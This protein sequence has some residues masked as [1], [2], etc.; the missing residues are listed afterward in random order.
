MFAGWI[1]RESGFEAKDRAIYKHES[2]SIILRESIES[3]KEKGNIREIGK[4]VRFVFYSLPPY[5]QKG[6]LPSLCARYGGL[7][8]YLYS[9]LRWTVFAK[10]AENAKNTRKTTSHLTSAAIVISDFGL[11]PTIQHNTPS[12]TFD[13]HD[14][15]NVSL[16]DS[17]WSICTDVSPGRRVTKFSKVNTAWVRVYLFTNSF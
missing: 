5:S 12:P 16:L 13:F 6:T 2:K 17:Y 7:N 8:E 3:R 1:K 15:R 4:L 9:N 10:I 11:F 14:W